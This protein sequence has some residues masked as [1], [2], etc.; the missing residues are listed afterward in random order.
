MFLWFQFVNPDFLSSM[1]DE[2]MQVYEQ[3][4]ITVNDRMY[5]M[6]QTMLKPLPYACM[7]VV[8][9]AFVS[10]FL[11]LIL[12]AFIKKEKPIF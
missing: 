9:S 5:Q 2:M 8:G 11:S 10:A 4:H 6:V 1:I 12:A 3:M 7:N